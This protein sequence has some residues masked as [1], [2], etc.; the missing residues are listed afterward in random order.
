ME[1]PCRNDY[2]LPPTPATGEADCVVALA[3]VRVAR[4]AARAVHAADVALADHALA[5]LDARHP[6]AHDID[7]ATPL[8]A[9]DHREAHPPGIERSCRDV[10]VGTAHARDDATDANVARP[11]C[12]G[13]H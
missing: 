8:V 3:Q 11:G 5:H 2:E 7:D 12:R 9:G 4:A 13:C 1:D 6:V 10:E